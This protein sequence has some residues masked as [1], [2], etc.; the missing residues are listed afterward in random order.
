MPIR[1]SEDL[2]P[3]R[4]FSRSFKTYELPLAVLD[5]QVSDRIEIG[6]ADEGRD[7]SYVES[8]LALQPDASTHE[9]SLSQVLCSFTFTSEGGPADVHRHWTFA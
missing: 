6:Y 4:G 9:P 7:M 1:S 5:L 2:Q 3:I 8:S